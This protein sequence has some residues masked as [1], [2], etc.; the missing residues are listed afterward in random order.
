[1]DRILLSASYAWSLQA[2]CRLHR[3]PFAPRLLLEQLPP[4][5][6]A[7]SLQQAAQLM[8]FNSELREIAV[9][10]LQALPLPCLAILKPEGETD[11]ARDSSE[12]TADAHRVALLLK[13]DTNR[14]W[15]F[16]EPQGETYG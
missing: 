2:I 4:P 15:Y 7:N 8:G 13:L 12:R 1:M 14:L 9:R 6:S 10:D 11:S 3:I 5:Y 16:K